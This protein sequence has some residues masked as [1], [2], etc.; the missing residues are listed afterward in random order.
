MKFNEP[1]WN[2]D[3][4]SSQVGKENNPEFLFNEYKRLY[5]AESYSEALKHLTRSLNK[6][7]P[8]AEY[9]MGQHHYFGNKSF[10]LSK[11]HL[12]AFQ[13]FSFAAELGHPGA[14][15]TLGLMHLKG[16]VLESNSNQAIFW[17]EI[18]ANQDKNE[19]LDLLG[20]IYHHG[21]SGMIPDFKKAEC[22]YRKAVNHGY[23]PSMLHLSLLL[24]DLFRYEEA[25]E[26]II[27]SAKMGHM[28]AVNYNISLYR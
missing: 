1:E 7:F 25:Y 12:K 15:Y 2:Y 3:M 19:A 20:K 6:G 14:Q 4:E 28:D 11:N 27:E 16:E 18:A 10:D 23:S 21:Y 17:L 8:H 13:Y 9:E 5:E 26:L 22:Y 24:E